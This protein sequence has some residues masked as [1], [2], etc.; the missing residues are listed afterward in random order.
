MKIHYL[1]NWQAINNKGEISKGK[2]LC[3]SRKVLYQQLL[4]AGLQPYN[5]KCE[6]WIFYHQQQIGYRLNFIRQLATLLLSGMPLLNCLN[7]L[8]RE[9]SNPLWHC[10]L[11]DISKK[12]TRGESLSASLKNYPFLFPPLFCQLIAVGELTGQLEICCQLLVKQ[13]EQQDTLQK[14]ITKALR[15]PLIITVVAGIIILLMLIFVLPEFE[16]IYH[17]FDAQLP[18]LTRTLLMASNWLIQYGVY[19]AIGLIALFL[20]YLQLRQHHTI[21]IIREKNLIL[22]L[23]VIAKLISCQ[24]LGQLFHILFMTQKAGLTLTAGLDSVIASINH[25]VF[26][27]ATKFLRVQI[28]QGIPMSET[29]KQQ[30][31]FPALCQQFVSVGEES[32]NL[33]LLLGNLANWYQQQALEISDNMTQLLE[34][35]L[36]VIIAAIV[37][38]LLLAMY[39]PIFQLGTVLT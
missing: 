38:I 4:H 23:P 8:I 32:G 36:I 11:S 37:G 24:Q 29:L 28:N 5:I 15:Y 10:V 21:W 33:E 18:L 17:S 25:P 34:P 35:I 9:C 7:I 20:F 3:D 19:S 16:H 31:C 12:I 26:L 13:Q 1:Y 2:S 30:S 27:K 39:L 14:K 6:K 22:R